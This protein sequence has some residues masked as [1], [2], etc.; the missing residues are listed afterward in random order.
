VGIPEDVD[1]RSTDSLGLQIV[2]TLT[3]QLKGNLE[4]ENEGGTTFR[5]SFP[6]RS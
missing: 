1:I 4:H 6:N 5:I 2:Q 3:I